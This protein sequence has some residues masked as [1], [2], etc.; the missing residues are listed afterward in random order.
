ML[1][2]SGTLTGVPRDI[3]VSTLLFGG[4]GYARRSDGRVWAWGLNTDGQVGDGSLTQRDTAVQVLGL[5]GI[6]SVAA[7]AAN[8]YALTTSDT[9]W[10]WGVGQVG[11]LGNGTTQAHS[12]LPVPVST[13][14]NVIGLGSGARS[15]SAFAITS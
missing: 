3:G 2:S 15:A 9:V 7:G 13:L 1:G 5:A 11:Q 10:A 8:G 4:T 12:T 6:R 14:T